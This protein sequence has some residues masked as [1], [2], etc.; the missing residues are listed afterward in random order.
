[1]LSVNAGLNTFDSEAYTRTIIQ[2][3]NQA[4]ISLNNES[5]RYGLMVYL[6]NEAIFQENKANDSATRVETHSEDASER[7][8]Q[9]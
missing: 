3:Q 5:K 1:M 2:S 9:A 7:D 4:E 8:V 6:E